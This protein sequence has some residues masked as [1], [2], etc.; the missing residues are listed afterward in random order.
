[1]IMSKS[2]RDRLVNLTS[3]STSWRVDSGY[4]STLKVAMELYESLDTPLSLSCALLLKYDEYEQLIRKSVSPL[5]YLTSTSFEDDYQAVAFLKK[6]EAFSLGD[7]PRL[8]AEKSFRLAEEQCRETNRRIKA[9]RDGSIS[10]SGSVCGVIHSA[11]NFIASC[12][13][14]LNHSLW[15]HSCRFGP[16]VSNTCKGNGSAYNKMGARLSVTRDFLEPGLLLVQGSPCWRRSIRHSGLGDFSFENPPLLDNSD[17]DVVNGNTVTFVPKTAWTDRPIAVEPHINIYAQLGLGSMIRGRLK[18][19]DL[20][21]DVQQLHHGNLCK[22]ASIRDDLATIDLSSASDTISVEVVRELLPPEWFFRLSATRSSFGTLNGELVE[23]QKFS[24]MGNGYTFELETLIF[25]A[26]A[27]S[28]TEALG[29]PLY[30]ERGLIVSC[31]GDDI[32]LPSAAYPLLKEVLQFLGFTVNVDKSFVT[33][34][35]RE[36]C[37]Y[38]FHSGANVRPIF[39]KDKLHAVNS[40]YG[41]ANR[42]RSKAYS[43]NRSYGCDLR[44]KRAWWAT[45]ATLPKSLRQVVIPA[46]RDELRGHLGGFT[47]LL[48]EERGL[49][50]DFDEATPDLVYRDRSLCYPHG[51]MAVTVNLTVRRVAFSDA[52]SGISA[53]LYLNRDGPSRFPDSEFIEDGFEAVLCAGLFTDWFTIGGWF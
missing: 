2:M 15:Y 28:C 9:F 42:I 44:F 13:G 26:L 23:Y 1:M 35:F 19:Y 53:I 21:L 41:L 50:G 11:S 46:R 29:L 43:R 14:R 38:D 40:V 22:S 37:G 16:G 49:I 45:V 8:N 47:Q 27:R 18:R 24:S 12:L 4:E 5:N 32:I 39:Q 36:T 10:P 20:D 7:L 33:G 30:D 3:L 51:Y 17:I 6:F 48:G 52:Y 25:W 34:P 31:F